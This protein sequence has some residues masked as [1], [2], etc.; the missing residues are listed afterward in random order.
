M[1]VAV[2]QGELLALHLGRM[3]DAG[4]LAIEHVSIGKRENV[5]MAQDVARSARAVLG[6]DGVTGAF[7]VMRH[8]ANLEAVATY[9]GTDEVHTLILGHALTGIRAFGED[10]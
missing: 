3:K 6:A 2:G 4:R 7:P 5:R 8:M 10:T 9:E 1:A